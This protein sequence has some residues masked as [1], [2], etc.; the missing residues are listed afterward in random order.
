[1]DLCQIYPADCAVEVSSYI[2]STGQELL[3]LDHYNQ[4]KEDG[5]TMHEKNM[6]LCVEEAAVTGDYGLLMQ[7]FIL[8]HKQYQDKNG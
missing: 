8:N 1:M 5:F 6:E 3:L 4:L 7:A 2:G